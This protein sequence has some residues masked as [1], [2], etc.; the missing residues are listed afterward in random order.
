M[1]PVQELYLL[2]IDCSVH[3]STEYHRPYP[4]LNGCDILMRLYMNMCASASITPFCSGAS[5]FPQ[6]DNRVRFSVLPK[7]RIRSDTTSFLKVGSS[8]ERR[9]LF[10]QSI[11]TKSVVIKLRQHIDSSMANTSTEKTKS[12]PGWESKPLK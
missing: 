1:H 11:P 8:L 7:H 4:T 6:T 12:T 3:W 2:G 5:I 10:C 9:L